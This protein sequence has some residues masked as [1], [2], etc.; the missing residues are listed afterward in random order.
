M[1]QNTEQ[2]K[3]NVDT[4][5]NEKNLIYEISYPSKILHNKSKDISFIHIIHP[6]F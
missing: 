6:Q 4:K 1:K 2:I 3:K 5:L